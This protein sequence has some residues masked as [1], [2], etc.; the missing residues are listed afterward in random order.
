[1]VQRTDGQQST[2]DVSSCEVH[3]EIE[4]KR[5][6]CLFLKLLPGILRQSVQIMLDAKADQPIE[7]GLQQLC[8][9]TIQLVGEVD[10]LFHPELV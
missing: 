7:R 4:E 6:L 1:M 2:N 9:F 10:S 8:S 5:L 3:Q